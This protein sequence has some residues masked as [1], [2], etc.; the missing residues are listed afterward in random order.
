MNDSETIFVS[1]GGSILKYQKEQGQIIFVDKY[2]IYNDNDDKILKFQLLNNEAIFYSKMNWS[3]VQLYNFE[4]KKVTEIYKRDKLIKSL[5]A[6]KFS[7]DDISYYIYGCDQNSLF[8]FVYDGAS[9]KW[10][11]ASKSFSSYGF[12]EVVHAKN[13]FI[14]LWD[15]DKVRKYSKI[16][17]EKATKIIN[18]SKISILKSVSISQNYQCALFTSYKNLWVY[19]LNNMPFKSNKK[20]NGIEKYIQLP[21]DLDNFHRFTWSMF[22]N[23]DNDNNSLIVSAIDNILYFWNIENLVNGVVQPYYSKIKIVT[24]HSLIIKH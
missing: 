9:V 15:D 6:I 21:S 7:C 11:E 23:D 1:R 22:I 24:I 13:G 18:L 14:A 8:S 17:S 4:S 16:N 10:K 2:V 20:N 5:N 3:S 12:I 19:N